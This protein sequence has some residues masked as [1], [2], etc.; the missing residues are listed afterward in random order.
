M[1]GLLIALGLTAYLEAGFF[2]VLFP[3]TH[4]ARDFAAFRPEWAAYWGGFYARCLITA[5]GAVNLYIGFS[6]VLRLRRRD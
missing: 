1:R 6:E 5:L 3:W 4:Y 2:L